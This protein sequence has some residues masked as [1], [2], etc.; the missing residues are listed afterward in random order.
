MVE[1]SIMKKLGLV[2]LFAS[3]LIASML[4]FAPQLVG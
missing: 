2:T 1:V 4:F 3:T